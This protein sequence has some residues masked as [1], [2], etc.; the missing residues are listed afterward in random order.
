MYIHRAGPKTQYKSRNFKFLITDWLS[1]A[2]KKLW[3]SCLLRIRLILRWAH[4]Y[5]Q[6]EKYWAIYA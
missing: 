1:A 2:G 3:S 6:F 5:L 4:P